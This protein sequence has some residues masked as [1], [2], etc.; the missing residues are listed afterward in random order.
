MHPVLEETWRD[1]ARTRSDST[2]SRYF[3]RFLPQGEG[4]SSGTVFA[5]PCPCLVWRVSWGR[6]LLAQDGAASV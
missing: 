3:M 1:R 6:F 2:Y 4:A 5:K